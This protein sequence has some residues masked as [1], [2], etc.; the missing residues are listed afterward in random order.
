MNREESDRL[1]FLG[2]LAGGLAHEI[3]NPLST[4]KLNLQILQEDFATPETPEE[5][6]T[7]KRIQVLLDEVRRMEGVLGDFLRFARGPDLT[8][9]APHDLNQVVEETLE[10]FAPEAYT[11]GIQVRRSLAEDL[12]RITLDPTSFKQALYNL[13]INARQAMPEG[14]EIL[15][16]SLL[17]EGQVRLE[18]TDTG[19][20]IESKDLPKIWQVYFSRKGTGTGLGL[21]TTRRIVEEHGGTIEVQSE[22]GKGTAFIL[23]LPIPEVP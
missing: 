9:Q 12:P 13:I 22:F 21:P 4:I 23:R 18:I 10:F 7:R 1:A 6:K 2:T 17:E 19:T 14:G 11:A 20:G 8:R 5:R 16:R 3:K 15:I